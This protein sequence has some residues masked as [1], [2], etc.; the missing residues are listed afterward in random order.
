[1]C[2][3]RKC[4]NLNEFTI[5]NSLQ[6]REIGKNTPSY[7][8]GNHSGHVKH[9]QQ[10]PADLSMFGQK[11]TV[12][13]AMRWLVVSVPLDRGTGTSCGDISMVVWQRISNF[14]LRLCKI[15]STSYWEWCQINVSMPPNRGPHMNLAHDNL[16]VF[17]SPILRLFREELCIPLCLICVTHSAHPKGYLPGWKIPCA[18]AVYK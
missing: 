8:S 1:M 7:V 2:L 11:L 12:V 13:M 18:C 15:C 3:P 6:A 4:V 14:Y 17:G 9:G 16:P 10:Q 5:E